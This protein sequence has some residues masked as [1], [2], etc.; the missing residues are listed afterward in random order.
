MRPE[1]GRSDPP[2]RCVVPR[3]VSALQ[4]VRSLRW[5][6]RPNLRRGCKPH[7]R[8]ENA[9][10]PPPP[11][12]GAHRR[13]DR[14]EKSVPTGGCAPRRY[15]PERYRIGG[16]ARPAGKPER[17][18]QTRR[19][20]RPARDLYAPRSPIGFGLSGAIRREEAGGGKH[21]HG[22]AARRTGRRGRVRSAGCQEE[23]QRRESGFDRTAPGRKAVAECQVI[24]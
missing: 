14:P 16:D 1:P 5:N 12:S 18:R 23:R 19:G 2:R 8:E 24:G 17:P 6:R 9:T 11:S 4:Y 22:I 7:G 13:T 15:R 21:L 20:R 3:D 10:R